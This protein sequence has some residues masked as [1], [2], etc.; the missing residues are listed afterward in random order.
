M[1]SIAGETLLFVAQGRLVSQVTTNATEERL[2]E[3]LAA[4]GLGNLVEK[5]IPHTRDRALGGNGF[6]I[7]WRENVSP[8]D[9]REGLSRL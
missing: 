4:E 8:T 1:N 7:L 9:V 6:E 2:R 3:R 5:V